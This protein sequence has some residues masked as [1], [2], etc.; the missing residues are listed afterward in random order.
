M[1]V[2]APEGRLY[3]HW[4]QSF[5][6]HF[7]YVAEVN[8]VIVGFGD[9]TNDGCVDHLFTHK[10]FQGQGIASTLLAQLEQIADSLGFKRNISQGK[11]LRQNHFL[12]KEVLLSPVSKKS[13]TMVTYLLITLCTKNCNKLLGLCQARQMYRCSIRKA[14]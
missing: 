10:N 14:V 9:I 1:D 8:H 3:N 11:A 6:D 4:E 5:Q 13:F 12:K 7:V 2:W